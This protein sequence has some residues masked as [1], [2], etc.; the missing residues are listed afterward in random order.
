MAQHRRSKRKPQAP[1]TNAQ[2]KATRHV[3]QVLDR[4]TPQQVHAIC[5]QKF[6]KAC[7]PLPPEAPHDQ[8]AIS[9]RNKD[10]TRDM[11]I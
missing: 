2:R 5:R 7:P 6:P 11:P 4:M 1:Q 10:T 3:N 9:Y 8:L